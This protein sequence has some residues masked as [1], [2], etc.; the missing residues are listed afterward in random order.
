MKT[1]G[2]HKSLMRFKLT[3]LSRDSS[4]ELKWGFLKMAKI[5]KVYKVTFNDMILAKLMWISI[6]WFK[7]GF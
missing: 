7:I 3:G 2:T 5:E 4:I 1:F 6:I